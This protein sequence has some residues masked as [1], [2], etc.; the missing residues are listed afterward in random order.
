MTVFP[1]PQTPG[2][3][4]S[5]ITLLQT[6][7]EKRC[8][9]TLRRLALFSTKQRGSTFSDYIALVR[10]KSETADTSSF[11]SDNILSYIVL[12]GCDDN[13]ILEEVLKMYKNPNFEEIVRIGTNLEVSRSILNALPGGQTPSQNRTFKM[14]S[15]KLNKKS[16][17]KA[18]KRCM[19]CGSFQHRSKNCSI[20]DDVKCYICNRRGHLSYI[21]PEQ[22]SEQDSEQESEQESAQGSKP[23]SE[24][25]EEEEVKDVEDQQSDSSEESED[26]Y[27]E[28]V[29]EEEPSR[30][31]RPLEYKNKMKQSKYSPVSRD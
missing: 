10:K 24:E 21:C 27:Q 31:S 3:P 11:T 7:L 2:D 22:E 26:Q 28:E 5:C 18:E 9:L 1:D 20:D 15:T 13:D 14:S 16:Q 17:G 6:E 4:S 8:P 29:E 12:S 23:E 19:R 25:D 30:Y